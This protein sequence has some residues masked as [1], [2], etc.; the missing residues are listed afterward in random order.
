MR[1]KP[2]FRKKAWKA[3]GIACLAA[4]A[5]IAFELWYSYQYLTVTRYAVSSAKL[6]KPVRMVVISDLHGNSFGE[7]NQKLMGTILAQEPD[8]VL[9]AGDMLNRDAADASDVTRLI[10]ALAQEVP[11]YYAPGNHEN[12]Y[13]L[14]NGPG[15]LEE[16]RGAGAVVLE[17]AYEDVELN[18]QRLRIGG[19]FDYAFAMDERNSTDPD[20]MDPAVYAFLTA[21]EDTD[22]F[23]LM[24]AHRPDSFIFGA[25]S[26]TWKIDLTVHGHAHGG[27]VVLPFVGGLWAGDQG[28]F[29]EYV[30]GLYQ[31]N[32][33]EMLVTSGLGSS[34]T[35]IPRF[36]NPP[37]I[38]VLELTPEN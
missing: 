12:D 2:I 30:H 37:E 10:A 17:L 3:A 16:I 4:F 33:I 22:L 27:Q 8:A 13:M 7:D 11:V 1:L 32:R 38:V 5:L 29:P 6:E 23:A 28:F 24:I 14:R 9:M 20:R 18:G 25:A 31:K 36:N 26:W 34:R 21:F 19:M 35:K 15:L